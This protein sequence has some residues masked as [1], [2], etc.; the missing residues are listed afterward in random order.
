MCALVCFPLTLSYKG[1]SAL[2]GFE[3]FISQGRFQ[4]LSLQ[5]FPQAVPL[6]SFF[7]PCNM[8]VSAFTVVPDVSLS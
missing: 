8:N 7:D 2:P 1:L 3:Y 5:I 4:L 6:F